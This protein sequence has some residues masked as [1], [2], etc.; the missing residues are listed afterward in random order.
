MKME[1]PAPYHVEG[2]SQKVSRSFH[3]PDWPLRYPTEDFVCEWVIDI[4]NTT[5]S[6]IEIIFDEPFGI[7]GSPTCQN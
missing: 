2:D 6:V 5:D 4:E 1:E 7:Y 3:T